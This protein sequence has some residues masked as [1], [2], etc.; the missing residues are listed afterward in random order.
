MDWQLERFVVICTRGPDSG[1][2]SQA[3]VSA[4]KQLVARGPENSRNAQ[5]LWTL[6]S[7]LYRSGD[8]KLA[9][10]R[11]QEAAGPQGNRLDP[12][13]LLMLAMCQ[14]RLGRSDEARR[15]FDNAERVMTSMQRPSVPDQL[16]SGFGYRLAVE[17]LHGEAQALLGDKK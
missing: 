5:Y 6:G 11:F 16:L 15:S 12:A 14:H 3:L 10:E 1:V 2:D 8:Y 7:A 17:I 9:V 4:A 13:S